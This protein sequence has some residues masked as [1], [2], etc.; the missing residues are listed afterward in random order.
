[1]DS[2]K[3]VVPKLPGRPILFLPDASSP[4]GF[5]A[6]TSKMESVGDEDA[7]SWRPEGVTST[8]LYIFAAPNPV[9]GGALF[10]YTDRLFELC[11]QGFVVTVF[12]YVRK[13]VAI[14]REV[15]MISAVYTEPSEGDFAIIAQEGAVTRI[16]DRDDVEAFS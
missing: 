2:K 12:G 13:V 9:A 14:N 5:S 6:H 8:H 15:K 11:P 10:G 7:V 4:L 1:M 16:F 3:I